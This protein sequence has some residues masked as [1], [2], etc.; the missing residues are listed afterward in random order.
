M[1]LDELTG[2]VTLA[3]PSPPPQPLSITAQPAGLS[4]PS[5]NGP[6]PR[7]ELGFDVTWRPALALDANAWPADPE[8]AP[9]LEST[10]FELEHEQLGEGFEPVFGKDGVAFGDRGGK[11]RDPLVPGSDVMLVFPE[12]PPPPT[13]PT[14]DF[15][16]R[17]HFLRDPE[18]P[19]PQPGTQ[20]RYRVRALDEIGR[21]SGWVTSA[22]ALLEKRFPPP[23]P[24]GPPSGD[25]LQGVRAR[26][27]VRDAPDLTAEDQ[28]LLDENGSTTAIVL[29]WAWLAEQRELDPWA[30]EFRVY[31]SSGGV[32]PVPGFLTAA[33]DLG[34]GHFTV[35][36]TLP[37]AVA[38][39]AARGGYLP[40]GG[41]YRILGHGAG[42]TIQA[43]V[44]TLV[45]A[46]NGSFP[47]PRLGPTVLPVPLTGEQSRPEA[48]DVRLDVVPI[49]AV[50]EY[51]LVL[52]DLLMPSADAPRTS[53]WLGVT[54]AD[55]EPYVADSLPG[56]G[57]PGNES[58]VVPVRCE[59]RY[60]GRPEL[61]VPP[62]IG[63]VPAV[64][65][66]RATAAG[67]EHDLD[68]LPFLA[69]TGLAAGETVLVEQLSDGDLLAALRLDG[70]DVVGVPPPTAPPEAD[71]AAIAVPNPGDRAAVVA[72]LA[73]DPLGLADRYVVFLAARHPFA[74]WLF[75]P[76]PGTHVL[77]QPAHFSFPGSAARYVVRVRRVDAAGHR[78][79]GAAT[80]AVVVRVPVVAALAPPD[81]RGARWI[82][83]QVELT[84]EPAG[85]ARDAP[86]DLDRGNRSARRGPGDGRQPP[87]PAGLRR[88]A[89][90]L[91]RL[92]PDPVGSRARAGHR[93]A[94]GHDTRERRRR[95][96]LRL[97]GGRRPGRRAV[98]TDRRVPATPEARLRWATFIPPIEGSLPSVTVGAPTKEV[99]DESGHRA[100]L[101]SEITGPASLKAVAPITSYATQIQLGGAPFVRLSPL[102]AGAGVAERLPRA[103]RGGSGNAHLLPRRSGH[104]P[105][106][107]GHRRR[108][109]HDPDRPVDL[110]RR[111][112][113][114]VRAGAARVGARAPRGDD[115]RRAS[116][117]SQP[118]TE[119]V[120]RAR[121]RPRALRPP[122]HRPAAGARRCWSSTSGSRTAR[123]GRRSTE[124]GDLAAAVHRRPLRGRRQ[125]SGCRRRP[126]ASRTT[127]PTTPTCA[128]RRSWTRRPTTAGS[129]R[130][131]SP[132]ERHDPLHR[133]E[134][135]VRRAAAAAS[136]CRAGTPATA[137][138]RCSTATRRS[139]DC[140]RICSRCVAR[141]SAP[142]SAAT[143]CGSGSGQPASCSRTSSCARRRGVEVRRPRQGA[144]RKTA[145]R[146]G[147]SRARG[148]CSRARSRR[149]RCG[150][151]RS[152]CSSSSPGSGSG[153]W[154]SRRSTWAWTT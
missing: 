4:T 139:R 96:A 136:R 46:E 102:P 75:T 137:S 54:A 115:T 120:A 122:P 92:E 148:S 49:T 108:G 23:Q 117:T 15:T 124:R 69:G 111:D 85:R 8:A 2:P 114:P 147:C 32:G 128:P 135:M 99:L 25:G 131:S 29:T 43:T 64:A 94:H 154:H 50:E 95:P 98:A 113:R 88:P 41:E 82:G 61:D 67:V 42:T 83:P 103:H 153:A 143:A 72:A 13:G 80:C 130:R 52:L 66:A 89:T 87:R 146:C 17:D 53:V 5:T 134:R 18:Q 86:A 55:A 149:S 9:P 93:R 144:R 151:S 73:D 26:V 106:A 138:S 79:A 39:D 101:I 45:P 70:S 11:P 38:T 10:R 27:L 37:R 133:P 127:P 57:R 107:G 24:V 40:A 3:E 100:V 81:F 20:H 59:A 78:S 60:H 12:N 74:D 63:D 90:H 104:R 142:R 152:Q 97:A 30:R 62:P 119:F 125:A 129:T 14:Q 16:T 51:E 44:E 77:G 118:W 84:N 109:R 65:T 34:S 56:G 112:A 28:A 141:G 35:D 21:A 71:E 36:L 121:R 116:P 22:P 123:Q 6:R 126:A 145:S 58:P 1:L 150:S 19:T 48:W 68:L 91:R 105:V 140:G 33:T 76:L 31:T 47:P 132:T 110:P 7:S